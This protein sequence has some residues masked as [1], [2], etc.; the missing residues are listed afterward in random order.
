[1][2]ALNKLLDNPSVYE[3][4]SHL[5]ELIKLVASP[6]FTVKGYVKKSTIKFGQ[7]DYVE[8]CEDG[9]LLKHLDGRME[10]P[11]FKYIRNSKGPREDILAL[12]T[13]REL[14]YK[15]NVVE[16]SNF[17]K[18]NE[19]IKKIT[20]EGYTRRYYRRVSDVKALLLSS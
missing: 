10:F 15:S 14:H 11:L 9:C 1:V 13:F 18:I 12:L 2:G 16:Y 4:E 19:V 6:M 5:L 20:F 17:L 7:Y 8:V 3:N